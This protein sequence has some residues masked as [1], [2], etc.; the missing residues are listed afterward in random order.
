MGAAKAMAD[1]AAAD[2]RH[3]AAEAVRVGEVMGAAW[4]IC[5]DLIT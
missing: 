5:S 4:S 1:S 2:R 3:D